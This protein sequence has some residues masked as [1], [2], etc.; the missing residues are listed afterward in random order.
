MFV[1][2]AHVTVC[3]SHHALKS[4]SLLLAAMELWEQRQQDECIRG[5]YHIEGGQWMWTRWQ[6]WRKQPAVG[7]SGP[8][9]LL[10]GVMYEFPHERR[11]EQENTEWW[12]IPDGCHLHH[13][14]MSDEEVQADHDNLHQHGIRLSAAEIRGPVG[15]GPSERRHLL[16]II[17]SWSMP[18]LRE[19]VERRRWQTA[20]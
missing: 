6:R 15:N 5:R 12:Q 4:E 1:K 18:D 14:I 9:W 16:E 20:G 11:P 2:C 3:K 19:A 8:G 13:R 7:K 10:C 17:Q